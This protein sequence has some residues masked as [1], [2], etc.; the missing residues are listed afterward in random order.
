MDKGVILR[1]LLL[2]GVAALL[3][4]PTVWAIRDAAHRR[5]PATKA[6]AIWLAVVTLLPPVG[7][8]AYIA[9]GRPRT[10]REAEEMEDTGETTEDGGQRTEDG[11]QTTE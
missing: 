5:F 1:I 9:V 6:K 10:I 7:A 2:I 8:F 11:G 3:F 4:A